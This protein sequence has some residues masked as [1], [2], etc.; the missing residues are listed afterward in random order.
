MI[1][2]IFVSL[3]LGCDS[4]V[5]FLSPV[6]ACSC[7]RTHNSSWRPCRSSYHVVVNCRRP[8]SQCLALVLLVVTSCKRIS[9]AHWKTTSTSPNTY[10]LSSPLKI[11]ST[12][13]QSARNGTTSPAGVWR[14]RSALCGSHSSPCTIKA[15]VVD[16]T[17]SSLT[18]PPPSRGNGQPVVLIS[19]HLIKSLQSIAWFPGSVME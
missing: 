16:W 14:S 17:E 8:P 7:R 19:T 6:R 5:Q 12:S 3:R 15:S 2:G 1:V 11:S 9:G 18:N 13:A 10:T 4:V